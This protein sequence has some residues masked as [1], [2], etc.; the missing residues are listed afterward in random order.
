MKAD[1]FRSNPFPTQEVCGRL[2]CMMCLHE[3]SKGKCWLSNCV[4]NITCSRSPCTEEAALP[5]YVGETCRSGATRGAQHLALYKGCKDNSF[6]WKHTREK[7]F[8]VIGE[9]DYKMNMVERF[10][11]ALPRILTEAV[12]IQHNETSSKT[13]NLNS[14]ME[15]YG[16]EYVRPSYSKGPADQW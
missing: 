2:G 14:K 10:K 9:K 6:L 4:Y 3:S 7:H 1:L 13:E 11:D 16:A 5:T 8:G 12:L 15:Y